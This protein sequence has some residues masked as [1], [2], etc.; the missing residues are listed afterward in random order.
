V[1]IDIKLGLDGTN[2]DKWVANEDGIQQRFAAALCKAFLIPANKIRVENF[3]RDKGVIHLCVLPPF[4]K[5][6]IDSLNGTALDAAAR[7]DAVRKCCLDFSASIESITLGEF[8][9]KIEDRLMD[10]RWNK[11]Y[12]WAH[13]NRD[14]G[15]HWATPIIQG[16][17][18]YYC[19]SGWRRF[20]VKVA[21][22]EKEFD[23]RWGNWYVAYHGTGGENASKILTSGLRV[24]TNGCFYEVGVPRV[25]VSPSIEYSAH[26][27]YAIPWK[28]TKNGKD[29]WYQLIFQCRV[30]PTSVDK[31]DA[32][33]LIM[34]EHKQTVKVDP[35]FDNNE[36]EWI[37]LGQT[38]DQYI[39]EDIICYG[40]MMRVSPVDPMTLPASAWWEYSLHTNTYQK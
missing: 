3:E 22:D 13:S 26:P 6:V 25:Y 29:F 38:G 40:L 21:E 36:L 24:S 37:I 39:T 34:K 1:P 8:G 11:N 14:E 35:N 15:Q 27:R 23:A 4:G 12:V 17:K 16:G 19:P 10:P 33:T 20:G 2:I 32:E 31:V 30:N 18:P 9:L 5:N 7:M 28:R